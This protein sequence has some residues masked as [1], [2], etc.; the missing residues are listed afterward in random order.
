MDIWKWTEPSDEEFDKRRLEETHYRI[1]HKDAD[2]KVAVDYKFWAKDDKEALETLN[3]FKGDHG[4]GGVE[5][6]YST[7]GYYVDSD[8]KR[9]DTSAEMPREVD[10]LEYDKDSREFDVS[11]LKDAQ[12][13]LRTT[14]KGQTLLGLA[15]FCRNTLDRINKYD[16]MAD[17]FNVAVNLK[18]LDKASKQEISDLLDEATDISEEFHDLENLEGLVNKGHGTYEAWNLIDHML[19]DLR[20]NLKR[21][22]DGTSGYPSVFQDKAMEELG[23]K[24]TKDLD[25]ESWEAV[26][27]RGHTMWINELQSLLDNVK[28]YLVMGQFGIMDE[29]DTDL[30]EHLKANPSLIP[31]KEGTDSEIDYGKLADGMVGHWNA[32][33]DAVKKYGEG[34][35]C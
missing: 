29:K 12:K 21:M 22:I 17:R 15:T 23:F 13:N 26:D 33:W 3:R 27:K 16:E 25:K 9:Y 20:H 28:S 24:S 34:L 5:Y 35:W 4:E 19:Y 11:N 18:D 6:F 8:G 14:E 30:A 32:I 2:G 7:S 1:Y 10:N 31:Y